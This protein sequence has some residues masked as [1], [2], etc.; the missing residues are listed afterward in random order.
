[1]NV[2]V[3][4]GIAPDVPMFTVFREAVPFV[5]AMA[6]CIAILTAFPQIALF[7][8]NLMLSTH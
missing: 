1:M 8:P 5:V 3:I 7:L 6:V 4:H 2:Y